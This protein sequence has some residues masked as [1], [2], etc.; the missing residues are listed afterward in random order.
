MLPLAGDHRHRYRNRYRLSQTDT[1]DCDRDPD[2]DTDPDAFGFLLLFSE[3]SPFF[4]ARI[5]TD[6][7]RDR[8]KSRLSPIWQ[9]ISIQRATF[10]GS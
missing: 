2:A 9:P 8:E 5:S 6:S 1:T 4:A 7:R 10:P 3:Q